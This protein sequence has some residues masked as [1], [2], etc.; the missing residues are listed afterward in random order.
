MFFQ[1][2]RLDHRMFRSKED[3]T[4]TRETFELKKSQKLSSLL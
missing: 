1:D 4:N 3:H 2:R